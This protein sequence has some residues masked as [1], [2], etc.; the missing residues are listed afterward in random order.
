MIFAVGNRTMKSICALILSLSFVITSCNKISDQGFTNKAEAKNEI[1]NGK[2]EGKWV[3]YFADDYGNTTSDSINYF[4]YSLTIYKN[5]Q[6]IGVQRIYYKSGEWQEVPFTN[7][8]GNGMVKVY[9]KSGE[10]HYE[11]PWKN[12]ALDGVVKAYYQNGKLKCETPFK[13]GFENGMQIQYYESGKI[14]TETS[15]VNGNQG[16]IKNYDE[17]GNEIKK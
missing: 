15:Y 17:N 13:D 6:P 7:G 8:R 5:D 2:K 3:E 14:K 10:L 16:T 1:I 11:Q 4:S 12:N 9:Y